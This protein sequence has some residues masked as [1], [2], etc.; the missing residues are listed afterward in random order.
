MSRMA[1]NRWRN[2]PFDRGSASP[3]P[4]PTM[5]YSRPKSAMLTSSPNTSHGPD[6]SRNQSFS[7]LSG[8]SIAPLQSARHRSNSA[9]ASHQSSNTFAPTFIKAEELRRDGEKIGGIEGEND[10][11][12]KRYVWL[13]DPQTAFVRGWIVEELNNERLLVQC[14]DGSVSCFNNLCAPAF[15]DEYKQREAHSESVDKVNPAKFDKA[16]DMAELTHLNDQSVLI[17]VSPC[18]SPSGRPVLIFCRHIL[19]FSWLPSIH[20]ALSQ[21]IPMS[22]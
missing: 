17:Y 14:D 9:K 18:A 22:T 5:S 7:P 6:H 21:Y 12:G 16:D 19:V 4:T 1:A 11:S 13:K 2:D 3:S 10:F 20:T 8:S 15:V